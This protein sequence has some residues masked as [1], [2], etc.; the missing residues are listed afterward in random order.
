VDERDE[1]LVIIWSYQTSD[2]MAKEMLR[3]FSKDLSLL[4]FIRSKGS[5]PRTAI[6]WFWP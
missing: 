1:R 4:Q 5:L 6:G 2:A 3:M